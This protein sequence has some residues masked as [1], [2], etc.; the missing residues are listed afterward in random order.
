MSSTSSIEKTTSSLEWLEEALI[1]IKEN[2]SIFPASEYSKV[3]DLVKR[4]L[5]RNQKTPEN[6]FNCLK[7]KS[8]KR[9]IDYILLGFSLEHGIGTIPNLTRAFLGFQKAAK[10]KDS[11]GQFFLGYCYNNGIGTLQDRGKAFEFYSKAAEA[12]NT[13]AQCNLG[14][15]YRNG[16]G[17]TKNL[18]KAF[19]LYSK[20]AQVGDTNAQYNLG[21]CYRNGWGTTK[22]E[23]KAFELYSKAAEAGNTNAQSNL[24]VCY[25][26]GW[27]TT[28]NLEKAFELYSKAAEAGNTNAQYNLGWCYD[29]GRG[30]TK[31]LEKAF[32]LYSKAAEAGHT[33]AQYNLGLCYR[34]GWGTTR[35]LEKAFE[36]YS[37]AAEAGH[38]KAQLNLG[39]C[40]DN[41]WGTTKNLE[42]AFELYSKAAEAGHTNA[43]SNLGVCY[44]NGWGT[45][46]N[47]EKAF[48][49]YSK[50]A[51]AGHT[52]AQYNLGLCYDNGWGTTKNLEKAF[53]LYSKAAEA[54]HTNAQYSLGLC[55]R[56]GWGTT[57]NEEKAFELYSKAAES[58][59]SGAQFSLAL[60]YD[61]GWGTTKNEEKAFELYSKA[62]EA[63][64][65]LGKIKIGTYRNR[66]EIKKDLEKAGNPSPQTNIGTHYGNRWRTA[67]NLE[68][69]FE[70]FLKVAKA[71]NQ[72]EQYNLGWCYQNG[73]GTTKNLEKAFE[74]YS[75][76]AE[77]NNLIDRG[78]FADLN[79]LDQDHLELFILQFQNRGLRT[80]DN[81]KG[82]FLDFEAFFDELSD[83]FKCLKCGNLGIIISGSPICP[84]CD[85]DKS[86]NNLFEAG[87]PKCL[88]CDRTLK[89]PLWCRSC[90]KSRF[91]NIWETWSSGN[92][93]IDQYINHTQ[94]ISES[95]RGCLEWIS[96]DEI[97]FLDKVGEGG[98]GFVKK[99][100]WEKGKI[101]FWDK[102]NQKYERS[103][104]TKVAL[105]YLKDSQN[106]KYIN[107]DEFIA[108][109]KSASCKYILQC[110]GI[111]KDA[112]TDE[113]IMVLPFAEHGDLI[114][115]LKMNENT[116]T[117]EMVLRIL[118]QIASGLRFIHESELVHGDLHP[119]NILVL[120]SNPLKVVIAD[121]GFC[122]PANYSPQSGEIYGVIQYIAPEVFNLSCHTKYS[123]IYSFAIISWEIISGERPWNNIKDT[124]HLRFEVLEGKRPIIDEKH[125]PQYVQEIIRKNWHQDPYCRDTAEKLQRRVID[126][127]DNCNLNEL[128]TKKR[129]VTC[130]ITSYTSRL[131]SGSQLMSN[132]IYD[133]EY[134]NSSSYLSNYL[135]PNKVDE[136]NEEF[137]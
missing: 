123:D 104:V 25:Q 66:L 103:G 2:L 24:G 79:G 43:Q 42:K 97:E 69:E 41:G 131:I 12:G 99:G 128:M 33:N 68:N 129:G 70:S 7:N 46:K 19:E 107:S 15:C 136:I 114:A 40:Y 122:R 49:L 106:I 5:V 137:E 23:G 29:N 48:E 3:A 20:A 52:K 39:L 112:T 30:T 109:L 92:N 82:E 91:L 22:N 17:T 116:L 65:L 124:M 45:T 31:N 93:N 6:L 105:K 95:S 11:F 71:G 117:W 89:D 125:T 9:S 126:A 1:V 118:F 80:P 44:Q 72:N 8:S 4:Y 59:D 18:E 28:K 73:W 110:Y 75:K 57:K 34:N 87:L 67:K 102:K 120:K 51:E 62:A 47:L 36:L 84:F 83:E 86:D 54:G 77:A 90:E 76:A 96:P 111:T 32:E 132:P 85:T 27:G 50:A 16:W 127:Y 101:L 14:L 13:N 130:D 133:P 74:I 56:N 134:P 53:E 55:Y 78:D 108:H 119:G 98:F 100:S 115:F 88:E 37:K 113:F 121:L 61:N 135:S 26:N 64:S 58:G 63:G 10:G 81:S 21:L 60:C 35:N 94:Q 38:T